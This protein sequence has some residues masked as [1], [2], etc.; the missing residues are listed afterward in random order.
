ME[1]DHEH[2]DHEHHDHNHAHEHNHEH[3]AHGHGF[4]HHHHHAPDWNK[5]N[6]AF[7]IGIALN[8][9]FVVIEIVAGLL[10]SSLSLLT[11]AGHNL[12]DVASLIISLMA[13]RLAKSK[14]NHRYTYGYK[15]TTILASLLNATILMTAVGV[16]LWEAAWRFASPRPI[17]GLPIAAV[18]FIGIFINA[19]TAFLFF[20]DKDK[21]INIKGAYLHLFADALVSLGV[22]LGGVA[23]YYTNAQWIDPV[24]SILIAVVI[25]SGTWSLLKE[26]FRLTLNGVPP[27]VDIDKVEQAAQNLP[28]CQRFYH[29]HIWALSTTENALTG[30]LVVDADLPLAEIDTIK[31]ELRHR[32]EHLNIQHATIEIETANNPYKEEC[33][34]H[35]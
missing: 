2:H 25:L 30:H 33:A 3:H 19:I 15:K 9:I 11:D 23:I 13:F 21:D 26:S 17:D 29:V 12:S 27:N 16:I 34:A 35:E 7:Y 18:A 28:H 31:H 6:F 1:H 10:T 32:L 24:L 14:S 22:V 8:T 4:G 5:I 20:K